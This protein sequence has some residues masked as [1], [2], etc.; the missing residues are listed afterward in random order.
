MKFCNTAILAFLISGALAAQT[1]PAGQTPQVA[2]IAP[3]T[4]KGLPP[5]AGASEFQARAKVGAITIG[6]EFAGHSIPTAQM[7]LKSDDYVVVEVG[8]YGAPDAHTTLATSE[9]SLRIN[10]RKAA[11]PSEPYSKVFE[12]LMDPEWAPPE[13]KD[14]SS[15]TSLGGGGGDQS[16]G[17]P[18][19]V[20]PPFALKR[21]WQLE[22][23]KAALPEGDRQ[24]P[25]D[26]LLFFRY[27][28]KEKGID[29]VELIYQGSAGSVTIP[30]H[31]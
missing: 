29:S 24:L 16:N 23:Q 27:G 28:G 3:G 20:H 10:G 31:P 2:P 11:T 19:P 6:A 7:A 15:K 12:S 9:F 26:G 22:T 8:L 25:V 14:K 17:P 13:S 30:L 21:G 5:R 4:A 1:Q 18:A